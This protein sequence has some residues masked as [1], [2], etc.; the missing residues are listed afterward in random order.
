MWLLRQSITE[1]F[2]VSILWG[3]LTIIKVSE[4]SCFHKVSL[5]LA[6]R[7]YVSIEV[8]NS[9][10]RFW[11]SVISD[12]NCNVLTPFDFLGME[13]AKCRL[14]LP[15][16]EGFRRILVLEK[17]V[18]W[19]NCIVGK[20]KSTT[21]DLSSNTNHF[22]RRVLSLLSSHESWLRIKIGHL[23]QTAIYGGISVTCY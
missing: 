3:H 12:S 18:A 17:R 20:Y 11:G 16:S 8:K 23:L 6:A 10:S 14:I 13:L 1:C 21:T 5:C 15:P 9:T 7:L 22:L 19:G 4:A 2:I